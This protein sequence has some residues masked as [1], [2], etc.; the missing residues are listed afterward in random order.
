MGITYYQ[1]ADELERAIKE[2]QNLDLVMAEFDSQLKVVMDG[3]R[4][5]QERLTAQQET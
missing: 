4:V 5:V 3:I 1:T 2:G